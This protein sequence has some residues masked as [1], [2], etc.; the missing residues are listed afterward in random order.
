MTREEIILILA[1]YIKW[2]DDP[3]QEA[4][5]LLERIKARDDGA[6]QNSEASDLVEKR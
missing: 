3:L 5:N 1:H 6:I 4:R 2:N